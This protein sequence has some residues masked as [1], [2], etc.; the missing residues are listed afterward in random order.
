MLPLLHQ[1]YRQPPVPLKRPI[2]TLN[3]LQL[4]HVHH[5]TDAVPGLHRLESIVH[6]P[7]GLAVGDEFVDLEGTLLVVGHEVAHLGAALD[8]TESAALPHTAGDELEC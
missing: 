6:L 7:E 4:A 2:A 8:A 5:R 3:C 1:R